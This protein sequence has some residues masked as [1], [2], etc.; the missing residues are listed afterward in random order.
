MGF[1]YIGFAKAEFLDDEAPRLEAWLNKGYQGNMTYMNNYFDQRLD[2]SRLVDGAKS[3][4]SLLYNY[5]NPQTN[6][7]PDA[8]KISRYAYGKDYH[9]VVKDKL[10]QLVQWIRTEIGDI[11]ARVF[12]DSAPI[13]E[14]AWAA[15]SGLG[16]IGKNSMLI[17]RSAGSFFFLAEI[18]SDLDLAPDPPVVKDYCGTCRRCIDACPTQAIVDNKTIDGSRCISY[19]TIELRDALLP[20]AMA[21][22]FDNWM[23]GCDICQ[24]VCP[25]NRFAAPHREPAFAPHPDLLQMTRR[26]WT[27]LTEEIFNQIFKQSAVKRTKFAGLKRNIAFLTHHT[28]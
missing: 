20:Q 27:E 19:F 9:F 25:W 18:I 2:P 4:I 17:N 21:G 23:F 11:N 16:W 5:Y 7:D 15:R 22:Q 14:R 10:R 28:H 12:V 1:Q 8:P 6:T 13:L 26:E 24:D 3:V